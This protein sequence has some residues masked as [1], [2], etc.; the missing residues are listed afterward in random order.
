MAR[1]LLDDIAR[2]AAALPGARLVVVF[3]SVARHAAR[4]RSDVDLGVLLDADPPAVRTSVEIELGRA[5]G[6]PVDVVFLNDAPP[7][8]RF[9]IA[10][11]GRPLF[12]RDPYVWA[13]FRAQ[14]MLDWWDCA[15]IAR[16]IH[17]AAIDRLR[18]RAPDGAS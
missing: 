13:E 5:A 3:G 7:Q 10:R 14:A 2:V 16:M 6:R 15:P 4:P 11:T 18:Q 12:A 1:M 17:N 9:E 8:L